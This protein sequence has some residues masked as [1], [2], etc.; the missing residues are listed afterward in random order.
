MYCDNNILYYI[1]YTS[2][3][4]WYHIL[5]STSL[6]A[7]KRFAFEFVED[8]YQHN[9]LYTEVRFSPHL[10]QANGKHSA[11][12]VVRAVLDGLDEGQRKF[13]V[14]ARCILCAIKGELPEGMFTF[15]SYLM[16]S[17]SSYQKILI[18]G[19]NY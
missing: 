17:Q 5:Y 13:D 3:I 10:L 6:E 9:V 11:R 8:S 1:Y 19:F 2:Y 7:I 4:H 15:E 18:L 14:Q 12:N 16:S